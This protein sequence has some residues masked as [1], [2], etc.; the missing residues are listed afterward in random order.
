MKHIVEMQKAISKMKKYTFIVEYRG[1]TY[2]SQFVALDM[3][4]ALLM[5]VNNLDKRY[6][7]IHKKQMLQKE[8]SDIDFFS[9]PIEGV[10]NV[11][12]QSYLSGKYFL[13]LNIIE[14]VK[15]NDTSQI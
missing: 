6:F 5:W 14:T 10:D 12:C 1:G 3:N 8:I 11:W 13:L 15:N 2:I 9:V 7:S 4:T